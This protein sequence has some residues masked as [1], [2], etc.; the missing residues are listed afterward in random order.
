MVSAVLLSPACACAL[1]DPSNNAP[2]VTGVNFETLMEP[3]YAS[4]EYFG[5]RWLFPYTYKIKKGES[6]RVSF[7]K[8][9]QESSESKVSDVLI[10]VRLEI[11]GTPEDGASVKTEGDYIVVDMSALRLIAGD[12]V[13][14]SGNLSIK[15]R[16]YR[17]DD[18]KIHTSNKTYSIV[19]KKK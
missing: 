7:Y 15:F 9:E 12:E 8:A 17:A 16:Y 10:D 5:D 3:L 19:I 1:F 6:V 2:N 4:N 18:D 11:L 13:D 14:S